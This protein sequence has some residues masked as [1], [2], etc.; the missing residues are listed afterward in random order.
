[1]MGRH[2]S[3]GRRDGRRRKL[4]DHKLNHKHEAYQ[5]GQG[6][7][8]SKSTHNDTFPPARPQMPRQWETVSFKPL[9]EKPRLIEDS[10]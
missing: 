6:F 3:K 1:M 9:E 4:R 10:G 7:Q 5:R 2:G 8:L